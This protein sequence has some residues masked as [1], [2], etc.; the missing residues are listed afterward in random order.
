MAPAH[1]VPDERLAGVVELALLLDDCLEAEELALV[2]GVEE[3][4]EGEEG[5][6]AAEEA[7]EGGG[8][9]EA[10]VDDLVVELV[11]RDE[12]RGG[13]GQRGVGV[14]EDGHAGDHGHGVLV[15]LDDQR[16]VQAVRVL[17]RHE[18][19]GQDLV[20]DGQ[21]ARQGGGVR[22]EEGG[23][24]VLVGAGQGGE[25][26][27]E[28]EGDVEEVLGVVEPGVEEEDDEGAEENIIG[29]ILK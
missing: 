28:G 23:D 26:S 11:V 1:A 6:L 19:D 4:G 7:G 24:A 20:E 10:G 16:L 25:G 14:V 21:Q 15:L 8:D 18:L 2:A 27:A 17:D 12:V 29:R 5:G 22:G 13:L 9:V 3:E